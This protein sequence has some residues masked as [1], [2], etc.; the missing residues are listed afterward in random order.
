MVDSEMIGPGSSSRQGWKELHAHSYLRPVVLDLCARHKVNRILCIGHGN[1]TLCHDL[2]DAGYVV[3]RK[4]GGDDMANPAERAPTGSISKGEM[5]DGPRD[6][7]ATDFDMVVS[8][9]VDELHFK[10]FALLEFAARELRHDGIFMI[11]MPDHPDHLKSVLSTISHLWHKRYPPSENDDYIK[12][13]SRESLKPLLESYG[14][15]VLESIGVRHPSSRRKTIIL[16]ARKIGESK[17]W[18]SNTARR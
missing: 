9:E 5:H 1:G 18:A 12:V 4:S 2:Q 7:G 16:V 8:T 15:T 14:F 10:P 3:D 13:W 11:L 17:R 6:P